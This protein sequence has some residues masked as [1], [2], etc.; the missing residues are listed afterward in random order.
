MNGSG[1]CLCRSFFRGIEECS[2][3]DAIEAATLHPAQLLGITDS[4]GTLDY[5]SDADFI[6]LDAGL[7]VVAT[8]I[9]GQLVWKKLEFPLQQRT[10]RL[11]CKSLACK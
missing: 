7:T 11:A 1:F 9:D 8:F 10:S 2:I 4:K 6:L 3:V 5:G